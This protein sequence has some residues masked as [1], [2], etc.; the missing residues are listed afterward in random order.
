MSHRRSPTSRATIRC[1]HLPAITSRSPGRSD[2]PAP[3]LRRL[4]SR[5]PPGVDSTGQNPVLTAATS[6]IVGQLQD[7]S[8]GPTL[9][10]VQIFAQPHA[11]GDYITLTTTDFDG[12]YVAA[13]VPY[14]DW[15]MEPSDLSLAMLG[16]RRPA[17]QSSGEHV[18]GN[19]SNVNIVLPAATALVYGTVT[20]S[21]NGNPLPNVGI[22]AGN[23]DLQ[24]KH[25]DRRGRQL[26]PR[27][28]GRRFEIG[29]WGPTTRIR[30]WRDSFRRSRRVSLRRRPRPRCGILRRSRSPLISPERSA[31]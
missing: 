25:A 11:T 6:T 8:D 23:G 27:R 21:S 7:M 2:T 26:L 28:G 16:P 14:P 20:N 31:T 30:R 19:P 3:R 4:N 24:R 18:G 10:G 29:S 13:S 15:R 1:R 22:N 9:R 17:E 12:V 5:S